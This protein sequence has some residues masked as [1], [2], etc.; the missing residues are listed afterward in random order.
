[1]NVGFKVFSSYARYSLLVALIRVHQD[2]P[3]RKAIHLVRIGL[4]QILFLR[5]P[6]H[7]GCRPIQNLGS[8]IQI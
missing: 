3:S 7:V 6:I 4:L 8:E 1:M 5:Q 2:S